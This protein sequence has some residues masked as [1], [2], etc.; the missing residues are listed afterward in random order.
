MRTIRKIEATK[1]TRKPRLAGYVRVSRIS[2]AMENSYEFQI[3]EWT[4]TYG[5]CEN[6]HFVRVFGD[7][8]ISG[9]K[10]N[11]EDFVEMIALAKRG[12]IDIIVTKSIS[13]FGRN[14]VH[15]MKILRELEA[16]GVEVRF[17]KEN[18]STKTYGV[19]FIISIYMIMAEFELKSMSQ[20]VKTSY[21]YRA[22]RGRVEVSKILGY[23]VS[24]T[25]PW[26]IHEEQ[27]AIVRR[28]FELYIQGKGVQ[29]ICQTLEAEGYKTLTGKSHWGNSVV[30]EIL[31]NE[32]Y[33]GDALLHKTT[34]DENFIDRPNTTI[35][36]VYIDNNHAPIIDRET[37]ERAQQIIAERKKT[38]PTQAKQTY[39]FTSKITCA[40]CAANFRRRINKSCRRV[41]SV[42]WICSH[43]DKRGKGACGSTAV[44]EDFLQ[45]LLVDAFNEY[46]VTPFEQELDRGIEQELAFIK[47]DEQWT[48]DLYEKNAIDFKKYQ[49]RMTE[50]RMEYQNAMARASPA[51]GY[52][53]RGNKVTEYTSTLM[54]HIEKITIDEW[55]VEFEF[56]NTQKFTRRFK[57]ENRKFKPAK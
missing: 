39:D 52:I 38:V 54:H 47:Q 57:Y 4:R 53:K 7:Y 40:C 8:G 12:E 44:L 9:H 31:R 2:D 35:P 20:A 37:F 11:R 26:T 36:Q 55:I 43:Q 34:T 29:A 56:K 6:Y 15:S 13:R 46:I 18:I 28:I 19:G 30:Y 25:E 49:T 14:F 10:T 17:D 32:K 23:N 24:Y 21:G 41:G 48:R 1:A 33:V 5:N 42:G 16:H 50:L 22:L 51:T 3:D 45:A 27:A